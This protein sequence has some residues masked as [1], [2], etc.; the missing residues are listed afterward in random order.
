MK[1]TPDNVVYPA[2]FKPRTEAVDGLLR[3][4]EATIT[5]YD[6]AVWEQQDPAVKAEADRLRA[7]GKPRIF[8]R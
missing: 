1:T 7:H 2:A 6:I 3:M 5:P 4:V 8:E